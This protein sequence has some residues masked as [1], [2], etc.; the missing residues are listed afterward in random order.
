MAEIVETPE[1]K[2]DETPVVSHE[3]EVV[4]EEPVEAPF[5]TELEEE[6][7][8]DDLPEKY[9]GKSLKDVVSMHQEAEKA[10]GRKGSEVGELR[11]VVD[12]YI[13][14]QLQGNNSAQ[15]QTPEEPEEDVDFFV[16]PD[17]AVSKA[18]ERHPAVQTAAKTSQEFT[19]Q[20]ALAEL[21]RKHPDMQQILANPDFLTWVKSSQVR[22]AMLVEADQNYN[23][24]MADELLTLWK[25][26]AGA[27]QQVLKS[28]EQN[29]KQQLRS[30]ST[31][32]TTASSESTGKRI[33]RR[34][35]I[36]KLIKTDPDRYEA[37][38]PDIIKAYQEGRV[39]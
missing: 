12:E 29:R 39:R 8:E 9:R 35:D 4:A 16:D 14:S 10:L 20:T 15:Q 33:Y 22:T 38:S 32:S 7:E 3:A 25:D 36:I 23:Q 26:R 24:A 34:A 11:K 19:R 5:G 27:T 17:K 28:E 18:I 31:G 2:D 6:Q 13:Q 21:Q 37:L 1:A 30:A